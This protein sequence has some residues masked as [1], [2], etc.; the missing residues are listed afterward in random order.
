LP[1]STG[2]PVFN[3]I[4]SI[5]CEDSAGL[6]AFI[7]ETSAATCGAAKEVPFFSL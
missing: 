5:S 6:I 2:V 7:A 1:S 3:K 4:V